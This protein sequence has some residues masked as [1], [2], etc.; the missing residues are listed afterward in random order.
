MPLPSPT[1]LGLPAKPVAAGSTPP[2]A[3]IAPA[4]LEPPA[5][6]SSTAA[7]SSTSA[8][9]TNTCAMCS[10]EARYTCPRCSTRT[11]SLPCSKAHKAAASCSGVR[12]PAAFVPLKSYT[13][14]TW[15]GD[16]AWLESTRRQV[17]EWGQGLTADEVASATSTRGGA[18]RGRGGRGGGGGG[19]GRAPAKRGRL[20]G[21]RWAI[22]DIGAEVDLL[23]DGMQR[24][25]T[26]QSSWNPKTRALHLT[27]SMSYD[28][29]APDITHPRVAVLPTSTTLASLVPESLG[30]ELV[31]ALP[32]HVPRRRGDMAP[33]APKTR[34]FFPPL[35]GAAPLSTALKGTA[36]VEFPIVH[37]FAADA[38]QAALDS[39]ETIV[40]PLLESTK[41]K[42]EVDDGENKRAKLDSAPAAAAAPAPTT[43]TGLVGLGDYDSE[44]EDDEAEADADV[45]TAAVAA[46]AGDS[47]GDITLSPHMAAALGAALVADFGE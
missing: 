31:Y 11:C 6:E 26:N 19:G 9:R 32:Y 40:M 25:K 28:G 47:G 5:A 41:R 30:G 13:Q 20:D 10:S 7:S 33:A 8:A 16:Y 17:A 39:G 27:V 21:L 15:D 36:F 18:T 43:A 29:L 24:R 38:W 12:D 2:V 45:D 34:A 37:V 46:G 3:D 22:G 42:A 4:P 44:D 35:D 23:P 1:S 14:G